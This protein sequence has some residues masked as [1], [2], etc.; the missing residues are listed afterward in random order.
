MEWFGL[1]VSKGE[2]RFDRIW[3]ESVSFRG[4]SHDKGHTEVANKKHT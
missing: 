1:F 3:N 2:F 4:E